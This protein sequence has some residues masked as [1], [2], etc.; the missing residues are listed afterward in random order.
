LG[1]R[2]RDEPIIDF[3][4]KSR[5]HDGQHLRVVEIVYAPSADAE[6]RLRRAFDI[7][8]GSALRTDRELD[9]EEERPS[10][11]PGEHAATSG[12]DEDSGDGDSNIGRKTNG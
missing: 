12:N 5:K 4:F 2:R 9:P 11:A 10:Q 7:L 3:H 8:L 1:K 6:N